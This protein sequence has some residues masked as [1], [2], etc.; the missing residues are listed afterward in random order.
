MGRLINDLAPVA[1]YNK[2]PA[3]TSFEINVVYLW[4]FMKDLALAF[5]NGKFVRF[6]IV[7][8]ISA[9]IEYSL[10]FLFKT[11]IDYL[12]ANFLAFGVTNIFTFILSRKYV[13][14]STGGRKREEATLFVIC[15]AGAYAVNHVVLWGLVEFAAMDDKIAK[16]L[17]IAVAVIWNFFTRKH[18]VFRNRQEQPLAQPAS[19][20][21]FPLKKF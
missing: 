14:T 2:Y 8:G 6:L 10:Y 7:G 17:A 11:R 5:L 4:L 20:K 12:I 18:I 16:A 13:F 19:T 9:L 3:G 1:E 15:L 21:E